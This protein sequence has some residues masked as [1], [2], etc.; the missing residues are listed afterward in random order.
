MMASRED[1]Y[2]QWLK[3]Q[4]A[5]DDEE[6]NTPH[7]VTVDGPSPKLNREG[8]EVPE[9]FVTLWNK[10]DDDLKTYYVGNYNKAM[11]LG[12]KISNDRH[13]ELSGDA[14]PAHSW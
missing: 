8:D 13:I 7:Y 11:V 9:W 10:D 2:P 3:D 5:E 6:D 4:I 1:Y 14:M 12:Q